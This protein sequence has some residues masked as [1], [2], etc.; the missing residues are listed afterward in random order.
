VLLGLAVGVKVTAVVALPFVVLLLAVDRRW[1]SI[2]RAGV[3]TTGGLVGMYAALWA[4][5]GYGLGWAR[6][7]PNTTRL[8]VEWT[9]I[10]TGVGMGLNHA[11]RLVG[12]PGLALHAVTYVRDA[13][14]VALA[15]VLLNLW[16]WA[17]G[18]AGPRPVV[19]AGGLALLAT[20]LLSPVAFPWYALAAVAVL[21]YGIASDPWR[22]GFG[23]LTAPVMLLILPFGNGIA[24]YF[25]TEGAIFDS[26][27]VLAAAVV[28]AYRIRRWLSRKSGTRARSA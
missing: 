24:Y 4:A 13:G 3:L 26:L 9:S 27:L 28:A 8:I 21:A 12:Q 5:T 18:E 11:L 23:L 19:L 7:L 25:K 22:Y 14:L 16:L 1:G 10:S 15:L 17:R 2:I 6:A 20:V